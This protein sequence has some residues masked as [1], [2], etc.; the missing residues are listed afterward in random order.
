M[1]ATPTPVHTIANAC[2][3]L[4]LIAILPRGDV[5]ILV[6]RVTV[7]DDAK[8]HLGRVAGGHANGS[9]IGI[10]VDTG[11]ATYA[12]R[13]DPFLS[14]GRTRCQRTRNDRKHGQTCEPSQRL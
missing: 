8:F 13:L 1:N 9:I 10:N 11:P 12:V 5:Q 14:T 6:H 4:D 3:N 2:A 7:V